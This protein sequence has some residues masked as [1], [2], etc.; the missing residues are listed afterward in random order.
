MILKLVSLL[1]S[2]LMSKNIQ[3]FRLHII[4]TELATATSKM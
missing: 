2:L 3:A 4:L 1:C